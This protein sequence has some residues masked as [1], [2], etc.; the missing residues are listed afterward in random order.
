MALEKRQVRVESYVYREIYT[1]IDIL[2]IY[3]V[4]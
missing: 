4:E 1:A 2:V 3:I